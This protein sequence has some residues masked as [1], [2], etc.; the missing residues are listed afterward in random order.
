MANSAPARREATPLVPNWITHPP[1]TGY[2]RQM[3]GSSPARLY[4]MLIGGALV[5]GGGMGFCYDSGFD[6]GVQVCSTGC[7][8]ALGVFAVN[9]WA[10]LL[11]IL[12][13]AVALIALT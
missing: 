8:K 11:H 1:V 13:G 4:A 10:N 12:T 5:I 9:G 6:T 2:C 3:E 7:D